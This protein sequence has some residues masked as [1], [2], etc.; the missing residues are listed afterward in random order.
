MFK[1]S[2]RQLYFLILFLFFISGLVCLVYEIIWTRELQYLFGSTTYSVS[3]ILSC[4]F[5]GM[6]LGSYLFGK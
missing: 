6:A 2:D 5:T 1:L 4:F 3:T